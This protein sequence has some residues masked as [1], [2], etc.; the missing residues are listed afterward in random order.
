M[1]LTDRYEITA[2]LGR[3]G[4]ATVH[5][6]RDMRHGRDVAV[7]TMLATVADQLGGER[8]LREIE[9]AARLQHPHIIPVFDSGDAAGTLFFVMPLIE[10]E[11]LRTRLERE[12]R[13]PVDDAVRLVREVADA[14][15]YAHA[16][17][18]VHRDLKPENILLSRGHALLADFG[19]ARLPAGG[20]D[21]RLTQAGMSLGTPHYMSPEQAAG[22]EDVGAAS[23]VY[24][25]GCILY[26]LLA[27][28]PPFTGPTYEA[29]LVKRFTQDAPRI[30]SRQPE[31]P[32]A[33]DAVIAQALER[34]PGR[35][36]AG[37]GAF[38]E[39]LA[40][41]AATGP[42]I[43]GARAEVVVGDR[44]IVVLPFD[45]LS[46][47]PNDVYLADGL[48]EELI[49]DL[50]RVAGLRVI[51]RNSAAA[52]RARTQDLKEIARLLDV[53]YLLEG[54]VRRA[55][56]QLR[57]TAQLIDGTTDAHLWADKYGGTMDDVFEMQ[58]RISRTIV[59][60]LR[61]RLTPDEQASRP[62]HVTDP[63][64]YALYLRARYML[65]QSLVRFPE[66]QA[67]LEE[68]IRRDPAFVP[69]YGALGMPLVISAFFGF[70]QGRDVWPTVQE[71]GTQALRLDPNS[72]AGHELLASV[73]LFRDWDWPTAERLYA[74]AQEL[75][76][77][78]G[79]DWFLFAFMPLFAGD[80]ETAISAAR[81]GRTL[82]PL[83]LVGMFV[84]GA[85]EAY[86]G[87]DAAARAILDRISS[88]DPNFPE[89]YH[90]AG[91]VLM[92]QERW[93]E[94]LPFLEKAM[95]LSGNAS[96]PTAKSGCCLAHLGRRAEAEERLAGLVRR[97]ETEPISALAIATLCLHLG[98]RAGF[99]AWMERGLEDRD[100][101]A[102]SVHREF[103]WDAAHEEP[104]FRAIVR[105]LG[106]P[107]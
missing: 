49:A 81:R 50:S 71:L 58:E 101:F 8:F 17:G 82:D 23:D 106:V 75:E 60:E 10:G 7:K 65:G 72:G 69:A 53:R 86:M 95:A 88:T 54:S 37:A 74:R 59:G 68:V 16:E 73:A 47:D 11:S 97:S 99:Y 84:E 91:Y 55:G 20:R 104:E 3:G 85:V 96:W 52:A 67:L 78:A 87:H 93:A 22:E 27:G 100:P 83:N 34:E 4:M 5:R 61:V 103:L 21:A 14:L 1:L 6:A 79:F 30:R 28:E 94:A 63:E 43:P 25:L 44:S 56:Q 36:P 64:T 46:P 9:I 38:G 18:V 48:T 24:A 107:G 90:G 15:E 70:A 40:A 62:A 39:R 92:R 76:P 45:N 102:M 19:I 80:Y 2:E 98:D 12:G 89:G 42:A 105:R 33:L 41:A 26:E 32:A 13:L 57:I 77:G 35:R 29:I 66:A 51:A 31:V